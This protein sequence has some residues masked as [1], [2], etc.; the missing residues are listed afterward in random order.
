MSQPIYGL[1]NIVKMT[2]SISNN[3]E[4]AC[5]EIVG[6]TFPSF[7]VTNSKDT[8]VWGKCN[9]AVPL[10]ACSL[11]LI[12]VILKPGHT[13]SKTLTRD[14]R[15][16]APSNCAAAGVHELT[17]HSI[18]IVGH[19]STSFTLTSNSSATTVTVRQADSWRRYIL[20]QATS[21]SSA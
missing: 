15:S 1:G 7:S 14:Q 2:T 13:Y 8:K 3:S 17:T 11:Y 4:N 19:A 6:G 10:V 9:A 18:V 20:Y 12:D 21:W 5:W 16:V